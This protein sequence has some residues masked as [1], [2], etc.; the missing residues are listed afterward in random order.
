MY[1]NELE[2]IR[3]Y[4]R[5][6]E[7]KLTLIIQNILSEFQKETGITEVSISVNIRDYFI[8]GSE[9]PKSQVESVEINCKL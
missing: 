3:T 9:Y 8:I 2:D 7:D 6:S 4:K 1:Q 5:E